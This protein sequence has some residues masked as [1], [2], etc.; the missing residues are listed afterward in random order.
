[1][2]VILFEMCQRVGADYYKINF[3]SSDWFHQYTWTIYEE[4]DYKVWLYDYLLGNPR[5]RKEVMSYSSKNKKRLIEFVNM[6]VAMYGFKTL[7][8]V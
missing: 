3:Q 8:E 6:F 7:I 5:A 2:F 1:M 4:N